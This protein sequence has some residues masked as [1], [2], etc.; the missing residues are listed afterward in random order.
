[1]LPGSALEGSIMTSA[2]S[3]LGSIASVWRYPV[4][5]M[6]GEELNAAKVTKGG[7]LAGS[8]LRAHRP[9][10]REG[11]ERQ[12]STQMAAALRFSRCT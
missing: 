5:S 11:C 1:V 6:M 3:I 2:Q 4:K 9:L 10:G 8:R 12:E 7:L